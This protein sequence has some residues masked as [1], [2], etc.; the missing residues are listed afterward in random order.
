LGR[1]NQRVLSWGGILPDPREQRV[2]GAQFID[3]A[4]TRGAVSKVG[5]DASQLGLYELAE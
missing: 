5:A 3:P 4:A 1:R 2:V